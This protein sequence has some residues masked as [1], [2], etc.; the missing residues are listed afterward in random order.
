MKITFHCDNNANIYSELT[1]EFSPKDLG[2]TEQEW[3]SMSEDEKTE[4]VKGWA[5]E[6]F[7]YWYTEKDKK[8]GPRRE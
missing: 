8:K 6:R 1:E 5:L 2:L 7:D 3:R 4:M